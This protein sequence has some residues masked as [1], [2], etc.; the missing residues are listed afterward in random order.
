[1]LKI[2]LKPSQYWRDVQKGALLLQVE[3]Q[4]GLGFL[5]DS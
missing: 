2:K 5:E 3:V 4:I 1:M